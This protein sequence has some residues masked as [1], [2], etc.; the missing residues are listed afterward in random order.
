MSFCT[1]TSCLEQGRFHTRALSC[2][3]YLQ[4]FSIDIFLRQEWVDERLDHKLPNE[5]IY[6]SNTVMDRI[7]VPD[8]YFL[9]SKYGT[10][11]RVTTDNIM[12]MIKPG[13]VVRYN[14]RSVRIGL[15]YHHVIICLRSQSAPEKC[16]QEKSPLPFA[17]FVNLSKNVS[18][19]FI[20]VEF[21]DDITKM[22]F[23]Q[24]WVLFDCLEQP[25]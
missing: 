2:A 20:I 8:S 14:A 3:R 11:H 9:N 6:L 22:I 15:Q 18:T 19:F 7:W 24:L 12:I 5:T 16:N 13:G 21:G 25:I 1:G 17:H 23:V 10:F 4:D